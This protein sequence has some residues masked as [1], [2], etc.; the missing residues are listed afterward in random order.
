MLGLDERLVFSMECTERGVHHD[1]ELDVMI[2][3]ADDRYVSILARSARERTACGARWVDAV[4][5]GP[6]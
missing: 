4:G 2:Q 6:G 5:R 1:T 3:Q